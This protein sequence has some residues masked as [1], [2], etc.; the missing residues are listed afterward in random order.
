MKNE[1]PVKNDLIL[2]SQNS[3][4]DFLLLFSDIKEQTKLLHTFS[5]FFNE[6][7]DLINKFNNKLKEIINNHLNENIF[8]SSMENLPIFRLGKAIKDIVQSQQ[9]KLATIIE[10]QNIFKSIDKDFSELVKILKE[11]KT[12]SGDSSKGHDSRSLIQPVV[13]SLIETYND[14]EFKITNDY[15]IKK[16]NKRLLEEKKDIDLEEKLLAINYL[17]KT[18]L[19][20]GESSKNLFFKEFQ[21]IQRK[22]LNSFNVI[23]EHMKNLA[24][25]ILNQ[26]YI[27]YYEILNE[28][29]FIGKNSQIKNEDITR[30]YNPNTP[31]ENNNMFKHR[32]HILNSPNIKV[33]DIEKEKH[34]NELANNSKEM[35]V[36]TH[37]K[38]KK[39][40]RSSKSNIIEKNKEKEQKPGQN[41]EELLTLKD[42]DIYNIVEKLYSFNMKMLD[43]SEY[44]LDIEKKKIEVVKLS[45]KLLSINDNNKQA[46]EEI[47]DSE[48]DCLIDLLKNNEGNIHKFFI[49]LNNYR[50]TGR[51]EMKERIYNILIK[52]FNMTQD[53]LLEKRNLFLGNIIIIL[54]QTFFRMKNE[55]RNYIVNDIKG[56]E[57]FKKEEFWKSQLNCKIEELLEK[58]KKDIQR[59]NLDLSEKEIQ[60]RKDEAILSQFVP[61]STNMKEF[62]LNSDIILNIANEIFETYNTGCETKTLIISLIKN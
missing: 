45:K 43:N 62:G 1:Y 42:E 35:N 29:D 6:Y 3:S 37:E 20:F 50:T 41:L 52:I 17:E 32:I 48:V 38:K 13:V 23:K 11:Y 12:I 27:N 58:S 25:I 54:S 33:I 19:E 5:A 44:I 26:N 53:F 16:Y 4:N 36:E 31:S 22:T 28:I 24:E 56:H 8:K 46:L 47:T 57:L 55:Q 34:K 2:I 14:I 15:I 59:M 7:F 30:N 21:E 10:N 18:F 60:R 39:G 9:N 51:Y 49:Q 40:P 61:F